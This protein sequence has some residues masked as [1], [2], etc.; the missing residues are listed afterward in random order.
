ML[1]VPLS[2]ICAVPFALQKRALFEGGEQ[3]EKVPRKRG[4][5]RCG[6]QR[7][8]EGKKDA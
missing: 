3:G 7:G 8:Q 5:K 6:Q 2:K 4:E 1:K